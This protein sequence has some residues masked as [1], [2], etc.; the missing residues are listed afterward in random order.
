MDRS[1]TPVQT[2]V[3]TPA[4]SLASI[5]LKPTRA[6]DVTHRARDRDCASRGGSRHPRLLPTSDGAELCL[7]E[8]VRRLPDRGAEDTSPMSPDIPAGIVAVRDLIA[9]GIDPQPLQRA[10]RSGAAT[11]LRRGLYYSGPDWDQ[12]S[13]DDRYRI[14]VRAIASSRQSAAPVSHLSAAALWGIPTVG[15]WPSAVHMTVDPASGGR[16]SPGIVRHA[17]GITL[18][19]TTLHQSVLVTTVARTVVDVAASA[20]FRRAIVAADYVLKD[21]LSREPALGTTQDRVEA[22]FAALVPFRNQRRVRR[23]L[24]FSSG[25]AESVA[26][27]LLR[28]ILDDLGYPV[29]VLQKEY[30]DRNGRSMFVDFYLPEFDAVVEFDGRGKYERLEF[31]QGRLPADVL[32]SEKLREDDLRAQISGLARVVWAD[33]FDAQALIARLSAAGIRPTRRAVARRARQ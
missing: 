15:A 20:S 12:L 24:D 18:Q 10:A 3:Q 6:D 19:A 2:P 23:V 13:Q 7:V 32:W 4:R 21:S 29:P 8:V 1:S 30:T 33:L 11:K 9:R 14:M 5:A 26:E 31:L 25:L 22:E 16:S 17:T 27:S 28:V